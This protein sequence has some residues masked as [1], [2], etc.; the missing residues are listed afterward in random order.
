VLGVISGALASGTL[1]Y[2][3]IFPAHAETE[4]IRYFRIGSG[5]PG[6]T[7]YELAGL[8]ST[9]IS[10]PPGTRACGIGGTCG[11]P[12]LIG[13][14]Q[15]T[16]GSVENLMALRAGLLESA[17]AQADIV[18][19]AAENKGPFAKGPR[20]VG[21]R[22]LAVLN[23][24]MV[25][26]IVGTKS[27]IL[28]MRDLKGRRIAIGL[29]SS[30]S[31]LAARRILTTYGITDQTAHLLEINFDMAAEKFEAAA[32][33]AIFIV[34]R[35]P[36]PEIAMLAERLPVR[37]IPV[38]GTQADALRKKSNYFRLSAIGHDI[39]RNVPSVITISIP[40]IW[41]VP[42]TMTEELAYALTK[43]LLVE[44]TAAMAQ[45]APVIDLASSAITLQKSTTGSP[46]PFHPGALRYYAEDARIPAKK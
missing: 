8:V 35:I 19:L 3:F 34:E 29:T 22:A 4:D 25:Q 28:S 36:S 32:I 44:T 1:C 18:T 15:T 30:D 33:D 31:A 9:A 14:A 26:V 11:V 16:T 2:P 21:L 7:L 12:G 23:P 10:N 5:A 43:A 40:E 39:Y 37:M 24:M 41:V 42:D 45:S 27:P 46:V 13:L 6:S 38:N 20:K 17:I